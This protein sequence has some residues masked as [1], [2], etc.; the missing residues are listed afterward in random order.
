MNIYTLL[1][2]EHTVIM[3]SVSAKTGFRM[4]ETLGAIRRNKN[5]K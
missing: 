4:L 5:V 3:Q 2:S 1:N